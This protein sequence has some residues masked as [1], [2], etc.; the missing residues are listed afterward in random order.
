MLNAGQLDRH[1][2]DP[3][4]VYPYMIRHLINCVENSELSQIFFFNIVFSARENKILP[5]ILRVIKWMS[6]W[7]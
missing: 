5:R 2:S 3:W 7:K 4:G 6:M 1:I